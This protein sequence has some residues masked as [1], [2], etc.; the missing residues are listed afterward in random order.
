MYR[1]T[2]I[3]KYLC[4]INTLPL[5]GNFGSWSNHGSHVHIPHC[6]LLPGAI[7]QQRGVVLPQAIH[8]TGGRGYGHL[9]KLVGVNERSLRQCAVETGVKARQC[10]NI[11]ITT[12]HYN[13][14]VNHRQYIEYGYQ[15]LFI[16]PPHQWKS[17]SG[18]CNVKLIC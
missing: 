6:H 10:K 17:K 8:Q 18:F 12:G 3:L 16:K 1:T 13:W 9:K 7:H 4:Y 11:T 14:A 5:F 15:Q 2:I